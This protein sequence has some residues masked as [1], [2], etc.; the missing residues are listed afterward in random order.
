MKCK[1]NTPASQP[2]DD[3]NCIVPIDSFF[4]KGMLIKLRYSSGAAS[5]VEI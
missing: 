3:T 2:A 5:K 1:S 4:K